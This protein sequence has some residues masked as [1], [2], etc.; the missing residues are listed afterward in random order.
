[1]RRWL[2]DFGFP[3]LVLTALA[4]SGYLTASAPVPSPIPDFALQAAP[5]YRLEVGA[6]CFA[7]FYLATMALVLAFDGRGFAELGTQGLR[8]TE[9]IRA[10]DE[11]KANLSENEQLNRELAE[12]LEK[13][14]AAL[15]SAVK[16]LRDQEARLEILE[17]ER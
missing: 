6:V 4:A 2:K 15:H 16:S 1:M 8:A 7:A 13:T 3:V 5:V 14:N 9:V 11:Q 12:A 10:T 17:D